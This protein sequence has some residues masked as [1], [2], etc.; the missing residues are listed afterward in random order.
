MSKKY[1]YQDL[2]IFKITQFQEDL[3]ST[4]E[5]KS[6]RTILVG[7][8]QFN[9]DWRTCVRYAIVP[10]IFLKKLICLTFI[11]VEPVL[12]IKLM[13]KNKGHDHQRNDADTVISVESF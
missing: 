2:L 12:Y 11:F 8:S 6:K 4:G 13:D 5:S 9:Q 1:F 3:I 7:G 10:G